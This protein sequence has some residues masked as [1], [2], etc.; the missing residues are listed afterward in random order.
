LSSSST[1]ARTRTWSTTFEASRAESGTLRGLHEQ[2]R[3]GAPGVEPGP[4]DLESESSPGRTPLKMP[5]AARGDF[6]PG[7]ASI[8]SSGQCQSGLVVEEAGPALDPG[9]SGRVKRLPLGAGGAMLEPHTGLLGSPVGLP[10]VAGYAGGHAVR[11][12]RGTPRERGRTWSTV[13]A[14]QP[15]WAPQYWQVR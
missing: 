5:S 3:A 7:L 10:S 4:S 11:P 2:E 9:G 8:V 14:S 12:V 13:M 15:G 1:L 6:P